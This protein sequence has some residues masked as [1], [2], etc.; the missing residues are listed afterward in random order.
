MLRAGFDIMIMICYQTHRIENPGF[1]KRVIGGKQVPWDLTDFRKNSKIPLM[2]GH[3][4]ISLSV[5]MHFTGIFIFR[6][7]EATAITQ[8]GVLF[9]LLI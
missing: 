1:G 7:A 5:N 3:L 4:I 2:R 8:L 9:S 6:S